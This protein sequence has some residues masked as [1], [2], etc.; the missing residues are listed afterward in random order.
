MQCNTPMKRV[1]L[2]FLTFQYGRV[3]DG[4][5]CTAICDSALS[6]CVVLSL[7]VSVIDQIGVIKDSMIHSDKSSLRQFC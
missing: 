2:T 6:R 4:Y 3:L 7:N 5:V 1:I